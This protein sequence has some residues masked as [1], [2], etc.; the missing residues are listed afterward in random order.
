MMGFM[1]FMTYL[2]GVFLLNE[3]NS[4]SDRSKVTICYLKCSLSSLQSILF[5]LMTNKSIG[6]DVIEIHLKL[7]MLS[8]H[9]LYLFH[10]TLST[11]D[12]SNADSG[13]DLTKKKV[14]VVK[15]LNMMHAIMGMTR[16]RF[17]MLIMMRCANAILRSKTNSR[18]WFEL[19]LPI[20]RLDLPFRAS[21]KK[22]LTRCRCC[23]WTMR[24]VMKMS[25][26]SLNGCD[27]S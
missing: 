15:L 9:Y 3:G 24:S 20:W 4:E 5:M 23:H 16:Q 13:E 10:G 7:F 2:F 6:K 17:L 25:P 1:R 14:Q 18:T 12:N 8:A 21:L 26:N 11:K 27:G 19:I 22:S